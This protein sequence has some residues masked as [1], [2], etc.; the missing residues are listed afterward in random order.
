MTEVSRSDLLTLLDGL[1]TAKPL[2]T[3]KLAREV[4]SV[5]D[6]MNLQSQ[7]RPSPIGA[8]SLRQI[9]ER[10]SE[11]EELVRSEFDKLTQSVSEG[12]VTINSSRPLAEDGLGERAKD[13]NS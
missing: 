10:Q 4:A 9:A 7:Y 1:K 13:S 6:Q 11:L 3:A 8:D 12:G 2:Q 5:I